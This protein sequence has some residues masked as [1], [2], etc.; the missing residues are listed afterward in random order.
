MGKFVSRPKACEFDLEILQSASGRSGLLCI[1]Q[2][3]WALAYSL[4]SFYGYWRSRY[5]TTDPD[6]KMLELT[7]EEWETVTDYVDLAIEELSM[8]NCDLMLEK[9]TE[10]IDA[11]TSVSATLNLTA[12]ISSGCCSP[13]GTPPPDAVADEGEI[14]VGDPPEGFDTWEQYQ[15]YKCSQANRIADDWIATIGNLSSIGGI[16]GVIAGAALAAFLNTSLLGGVLVGVMA[17]GFSAGTAATLIIA[18]LI[19]LIAGGVGLFAYFIDLS[20][21]MET[22]KQDLVCALY[23]ATS[24]SGAITAISDFTADIAAGLSYDPGDDDSLFQS[25]VGDIAGA[26]INTSVINGLFDGSLEPYNGELDCTCSGVQ[27]AIGFHFGS[28]DLSRS[29]NQRT[30]TAEYRAG[31]NDYVIMFNVGAPAYYSD[32]QCADMPSPCKGTNGEQFQCTIHSAT[33]TIHHH[34][35]SKCTNGTGAVVINQSSLNTTQNY[36]TFVELFSYSPFT[37][38]VTISPK[39]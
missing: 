7:D 3:T 24:V 17:V 5:Y 26:I 34:Y 37:A 30:L 28:G 23:N 12:S 36:C 27:C 15:E 31:N 14:G 35:A 2:S 10:L 21:D 11:V 22:D 18:A 39:V 1:S 8:S 6:G 29:G 19:A 4:V 16:V 38:E 13:Y 25:V 20:A 9:L 33:A 32:W